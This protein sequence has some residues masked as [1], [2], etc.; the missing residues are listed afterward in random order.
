MKVLDKVKQ[1]FPSAANVKYDKFEE[2][3]LV[4]DFTQKYI[5]M[6]DEEELEGEVYSVSVYITSKMYH[7]EHNYISDG[8]EH[9]LMDFDNNFEDCEDVDDYEDCCGIFDTFFDNI[10]RGE[11]VLL[12]L[13]SSTCMDSCWSFGECGNEMSVKDGFLKYLKESDKFILVED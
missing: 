7:D 3:F 5:Y 9:L 11:F 8:G 6:I 13:Y 10:T 2:C 4:N 1:I 12:G